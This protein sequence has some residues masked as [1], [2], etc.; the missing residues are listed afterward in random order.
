MRLLVFLT[1]K[2]SVKSEAYNPEAFITLFQCG[3]FLRTNQNSRPYYRIT[4]TRVCCASVMKILYCDVHC[5]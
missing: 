4:D 1:P 3:F 2:I 5:Q